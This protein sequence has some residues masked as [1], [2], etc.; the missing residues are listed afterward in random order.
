L[1][2]STIFQT[3]AAY[4]PAATDGA[5]AAFSLATARL[6]DAPLDAKVAGTFSGILWT[7]GA[8]W[9][10]HRNKPRSYVVSGANFLGGAAGVLSVGATFALGDD[11]KKVA[12]AS[13]ASWAANGFANLVRAG[14]RTGDG[15]AVDVWLAASG[16]ANLGAALLSATEASAAANDESTKATNL[17]TISAVFWLAGAVTAAAAVYAAGLGNRGMPQPPDLEAGADAI[18]LPTRIQVPMTE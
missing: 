13:A 4:G 18:E 16:L 11:T 15:V 6:S 7:L 8:V 17:G 10:E 5:A 14:A 3:I 9:Q 2:T 1:Q 12:Y